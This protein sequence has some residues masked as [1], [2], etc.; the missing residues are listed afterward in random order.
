MLTYNLLND[1]L[2]FRTLVDTFFNET[3]EHRG[4]PS[5]EIH[6]EEDSIEIRALVPG[7][8]SENLNLELEKDFL[9]IEGE[10]AAPQG[11]KKHLR[12]ERNFGTFS[13]KI[14]LPYS[15]DS[16]KIEASLKDGILKVTLHKSEDAKPKKIAIQ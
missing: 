15:V 12:K 7:V 4:Y 14:K 2:N 11:E 6:T 3:P 16:S 13:R 9:K 5:I 1:T 8:S 10:K